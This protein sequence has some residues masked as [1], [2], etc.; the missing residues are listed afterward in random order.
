MNQTKEW[1]TKSADE[2]LFALKY[3]KRRMIVPLMGGL[4]FIPMEFYALFV[5]VS[6]STF[7][8]IMV[9]SGAIIFLLIVIPALADMLL[10]KEIRFYKDRIVKTWKL[11]SG[12]ELQLAQVGLRCQELLG[13]GKK[14]F[15]EQGRNPYW[16]W[17]PAMFHISGISYNEQFADRKKV[18][19]LNSLLA[20]LS[21]RKVEEFEQTVTMDRLVKKEKM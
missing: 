6:R 7:E 15:F 14:S 21:G 4:F 11:A 12:R 17:L 8:L 16:G 9:K 1:E 13:I 2:P 18:K 3:M 5:H 20:E 19:Q 10:L